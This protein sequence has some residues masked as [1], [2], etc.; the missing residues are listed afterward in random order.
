MVAGLKDFLTSTDEATRNVLTHSLEAHDIPVHTMTGEQFMD[1][2]RTN[3]EK[4]E[5][6][7]SAASNAGHTLLTPEDLHRLWVD[8]A[9]L[10]GAKTVRDGFAKNRALYNGAD[11]QKILNGPLIA[12][13]WRGLSDAGRRAF[14]KASKG[15]EAFASS[16]EK[17]SKAPIGIQRI[18]GTEKGQL[19][20]DV[21]MSV[22][23]RLAK[24]FNKSP[25]K[26]LGKLALK[27]A[28]FGTA[29][30]EAMAHP[31]LVG[32]AM[33]LGAAGMGL[34]RGAEKL[35]NRAAYRITQKLLTTD[36]GVK[37]LTDGVRM[38]AEG[39]PRV[40]IANALART[41]AP[42]L[43]AAWGFTQDQPQGAGQ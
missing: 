15:M 41:V 13:Q 24:Q 5:A 37:M 8:D 12:Q 4:I 34:K 9:I 7:A 14:G 26:T 35:G 33:A 38:M 43:L 28:G 21:F 32:G 30:M 17:L 20:M 42:D 10:G 39:H 6:A 25:M 23:E 19:P 31:K 36:G 2:L 16:V 27:G 40:V 29:G 1:V 3:P 22:Y 18:V 11:G